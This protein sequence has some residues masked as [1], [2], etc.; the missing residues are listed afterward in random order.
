MQTLSTSLRA[1]KH[2]PSIFIPLLFCLLLTMIW[3]CTSRPSSRKEPLLNA[4]KTI[5]EITGEDT[6]E[7]ARTSIL[8]EKSEYRLT[9]YLDTTAIKQYPCVFGFNPTDDKRME[10]DGCTPEGKFKLRSIYPHDKWSRFMWVDYPT[11]ESE[12]KH[13]A[14]KAAG[15]IPASATIGGEI[16]IHGTPA[17]LGPM[18]DIKDN[19]TLGCISLKNR[20]VEELYENVQVG[21]PVEILH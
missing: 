13:A 2:R 16:G 18:I 20:D 3:S 6:L 15:E 19:W 12:E 1:Q 17:G 8:I 11:A 5:L 21:T 7:S 9:L 4:K 10:G 14:S